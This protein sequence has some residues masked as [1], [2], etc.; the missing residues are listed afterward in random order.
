MRRLIVL[1][2]AAGFSAGEIDKGGSFLD[3]SASSTSGW[4]LS[5]R[6]DSRPSPPESVSEKKKSAVR[7]IIGRSTN[8]AI[9]ISTRGTLL[10]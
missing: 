10:K 9:E 8:M 2:R 1:N 5:A 3:E 4:K 6:V 7:S